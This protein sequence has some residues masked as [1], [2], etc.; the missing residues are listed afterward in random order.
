MSELFSLVED[1]TLWFEHFSI[2]EKVSKSFFVYLE[3]YRKIE[4]EEFKE[5]FLA[6]S[7]EKLTIE[8]QNLEIFFSWLDKS[9]SYVIVYLPIIY[10]DVQIGMY[11]TMFDSA[12]MII[13][14]SWSYY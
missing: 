14:T 13:N 2:K 8:V 5:T 1:V 6:F 11:K 3:N 10:N 9:F 7:V 4:S 12:G